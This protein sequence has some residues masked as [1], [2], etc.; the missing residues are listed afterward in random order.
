MSES[1]MK[2]AMKNA[3]ASV[4]MEGLCVP[5]YSKELCEKLL[6]NEIT[7]DEYIKLSLLRV[8]SNVV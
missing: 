3:E 6:K 7:L 5:D 8:K 1:A 4:N 2:K